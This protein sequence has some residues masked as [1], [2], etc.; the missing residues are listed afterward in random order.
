MLRQLKVIFFRIINVQR[1]STIVRKF[2]VRVEVCGEQQRQRYRVLLILKITSLLLLVPVAVAV[3]VIVPAGVIS[4]GGEQLLT[5]II[6]VL[7]FNG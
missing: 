3:G 4:E 1:R 6:I 7:S 2:V 5:S